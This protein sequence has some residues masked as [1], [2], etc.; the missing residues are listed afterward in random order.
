MFAPSLPKARTRR[1]PSAALQRIFCGAQ[2]CG[3]LLQHELLLALRDIAPQSYARLVIETGIR[4][5]KTEAI[6]ERGQ[7]VSAAGAVMLA[8]AIAREPEWSRIFEQ[9]ADSLTARLYYE[10]PFSLKFALNNLPRTLRVKLAFSTFA[11]RMHQV[12]GSSSQMAHFKRRGH[13]AYVQI[14]D[15]MFAD[16]LETRAGAREFYGAALRGMFWHFARIEC[17]VSE[18]SSDQILLHECWYAAQWED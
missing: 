8:H 9:A 18:V 17:A 7:I 2:S 11:S 10:L 15:G 12:G 1:E 6:A 5:D 16:Y 14:K 4:L 13:R 3:P